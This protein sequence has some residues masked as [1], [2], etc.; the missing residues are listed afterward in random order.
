MGSLMGNRS[1]SPS[2]L[3]LASASPRR[4]DLLEQI[5]VIPSRIEG[6]D[7]DESLLVDEQPRVAVARLAK[8][9]AQAAQARQGPNEII[10][11]ADT[12]VACGRRILGKPADEADARRM[13]EL[14]SGR[15]HQVLTGL[16]LVTC[17]GKFIART[18]MTRVSFKRLS[19]RELFAYLGSG[20]WE[21][22]AGAYAIQGRAEAFVKAI[23]G[24]YSNV[25]GLPLHE[26]ANLLV[27]AGY[28]VYSGDGI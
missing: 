1:S 21:G 19:E 25:V 8:L 27:G 22:K 6:V 13:L 10:L 3:F 11:A 5:C 20:E 26:T 23:E 24:S 7:V 2:K 9:K 17:E 28:P 16:C 14:L 15:R 18:V 12:L 4:K